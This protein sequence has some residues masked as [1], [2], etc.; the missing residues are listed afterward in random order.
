MNYSTLSAAVIVAFGLGACAGPQGPAGAQ[1]PTGQTGR[2]SSDTLIV[3]P[4]HPSARTV[5]TVI[6]SPTHP[7]RTDTVIVSPAPT[8]RTTTWSDDTGYY[9]R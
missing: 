6:V 5:D 9:Y 7:T 2:T 1:G 8:T 3:S 4:A